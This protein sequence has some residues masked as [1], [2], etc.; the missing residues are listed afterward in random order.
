MTDKNL[1]NLATQ[2]GEIL[3]QRGEMLALAESCTGGWLGQVATAIPGSS[4]WFERGFVTYSNHAKIQMLGVP[5]KQVSA[6]GAVSQP[7]VEYMA[8]GALENSMAQWSIAVS[9]VAGPDGGTQARPVGTVWIAWARLD[10]APEAQR[11][12][13]SGDR[14]AVRRASVEQAYQ[15]LLQRLR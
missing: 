12:N 11:C 3:L 2:V 6:H 9:G 7:V 13:F 4:R 15:G 10:K 14:D 8:A 5:E 1:Q